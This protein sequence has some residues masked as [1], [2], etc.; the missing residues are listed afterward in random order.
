[1]KQLRHILIAVLVLLSV[2]SLAYSQR[3]MR[4]KGNR[5]SDPASQYNRLYDTK[6][7]ETISGDV[8]AIDTVAPSKRMAGGIHLTLKTDK[9][10]ISVHLGPTWYM[11]KQ[12]VKLAVGDKITVKG[13]RITYDEKPAI[14]AAEITRGGDTLKLRSDNGFPLWSRGRK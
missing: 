6:T 9:E 11:E 7:V 8:T 1:M 3:G 14:V 13:S 12:D 5:G 2:S 4:G 10:T